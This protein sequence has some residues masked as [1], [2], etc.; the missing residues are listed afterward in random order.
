MPDPS[1]IWDL[2]CNLWQCWILNPLSEAR[3]W[4]HIL[5][6]TSQVLNP[7]SHNGNSLLTEIVIVNCSLKKECPP[8]L[9]F[10]AKWA[11]VRIW[12]VH[13]SR[14]NK[15][16]KLIILSVTLMRIGVKVIKNFSITGG[17]TVGD[18]FFQKG[19]F[20][21]KSCIFGLWWTAN[22]WLQASATGHL[23]TKEISYFAYY[24]DKFYSLNIMQYLILICTWEQTVIN[25][26]SYTAAPPAVL[27]LP[28]DISGVWISILHTSK[29]KW[30][31]NLLL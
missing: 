4:A 16:L 11:C 29:S 21:V 13:A 27:I 20:Y 9:F 7:M 6:D 28:R 22:H 17:L 26:A 12:M 8:I 15:I 18:I 1:H 3:D 25:T 23:G 10:P 24:T 5:M 30:L 14:T 19:K 2:C 31:F